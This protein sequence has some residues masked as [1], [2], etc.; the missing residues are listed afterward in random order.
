MAGPACSLQGAG[1]GAGLPVLGAPW[2]RRGQGGP[3]VDDSAALAD[4]GDPRYR[5]GGVHEERLHL[6][7]GGAGPLVENQGSRTGNHRRRLRSAA[8]EEEPLSDPGLG[9]LEVGRGAGDPEAHHRAT[10]GDQVDVAA[11]GPA[12]GEESE[13][14]VAGVARPGGVHRTDGEHEG[15]AGRVA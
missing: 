1:A 15:I 10:R 5:E 8:A 4:G 11:L 6:I 2:G 14:I 9:V 12:A 7:G 3:E 13:L